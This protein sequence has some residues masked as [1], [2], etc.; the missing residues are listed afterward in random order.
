MR[1]IRTLTYK[2]TKHSEQTNEFTHSK[3]NM[4]MSQP[5]KSTK[6]WPD[7]AESW[8]RC[9][10]GHVTCG[11][12][13]RTSTRKREMRRATVLC[14]TIKIWMFR[15]HLAKDMSSINFTYL[16]EIIPG[17]CVII[18][19]KHWSENTR[20]YATTLLVRNVYR[21][22]SIRYRDHFPIQAGLY[23]RWWYTPKADVAG[24]GR[25]WF[26]PATSGLYLTPG[27]S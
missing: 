15:V 20:V 17:H 14:K 10:P 21:I 4:I 24:T 8:Q 6:D 2:Y 12:T 11:E 3:S 16:Y 13:W 25:D 19:P 23:W 18:R 5:S 7:S 26:E 1:V 9:L 22:S 27:L